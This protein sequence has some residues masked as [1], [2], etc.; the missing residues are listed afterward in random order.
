[1]WNIPEITDYLKISTDKE[2]KDFVAIYFSEHFKSTREEQNLKHVAKLP[3][4]FLTTP[5]EVE[6]YVQSN[7]FE[8]NYL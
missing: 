8:S 5:D 1:M 4:I 3:Y 2:A 6:N 7:Y